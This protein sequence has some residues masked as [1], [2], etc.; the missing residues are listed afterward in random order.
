MQLPYEWIAQLA[1][2]RVT[3]K[4]VLLKIFICPQ[5]GHG[6][7]TGMRTD[8]T[9]AHGLGPGRARLWQSYK[10]AFCNITESVTDGPGLG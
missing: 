8:W 5:Q 7:G 2:C 10:P 6:N 4:E 1:I 9:S 3:V